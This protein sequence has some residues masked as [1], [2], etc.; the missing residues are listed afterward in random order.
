MAPATRG[1]GTRGGK[2]D[3]AA[4]LALLNGAA[5]RAAACVEDEIVEDIELEIAR[6]SD[7]DGGTLPLALFAPVL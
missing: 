7:L 6:A 4:A 2:V 1:R 3:D 5:L